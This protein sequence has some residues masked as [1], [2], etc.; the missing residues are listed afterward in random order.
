[1]YCPFVTS[2]REQLKTNLQFADPINRYEIA[3]KQRAKQLAAAIQKITQS[4]KDAPQE[5]SDEL[6]YVNR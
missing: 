3:Q 4:G 2:Y 1:M 6:D 5:L